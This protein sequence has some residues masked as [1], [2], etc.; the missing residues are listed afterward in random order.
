MALFALLTAVVGLAV[1]FIRKKITALISLVIAVLGVV[2]LFL[3]KIN[4]DGDAALSG[5]GIIKLEYQSGYWLTIIL[6]IAAAVVQWLIYN[7]KKKPESV[8]TQTPTVPQ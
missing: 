5:Q 6:F 8:I 2:F 3:L 7:E 4:M 1:G